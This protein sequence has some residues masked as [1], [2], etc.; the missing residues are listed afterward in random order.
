[1]KAIALSAILIIALF[2]A[3]A[4]AAVLGDKD[5][6]ST[7]VCS[8]GEGDC[9]SDSQCASGL[10]C[11]INSGSNYGMP[12][13]YD[14]CINPAVFDAVGG[15]YNGN[16][17]YCSLKALVGQKC[18]EGQGDCDSDDECQSGLICALDI[19]GRVFGVG[20]EKTDVCTAPANLQSG[21]MD[22]CRARVLLGQKC[23]EAEGDCDSDAECISDAEHNTTCVPDNGAKFGFLGHIDVCATPTTP[24]TKPPVQNGTQ[25]TS[26][27]TRTDYT[28]STTPSIIHN[29][30]FS[31]FYDPGTEK[32]FVGQEISGVAVIDLTDNSR[33]VYRASTTPG[34]D[35][36][37]DAVRSVFYDPG[38][39]KMFVA[40]ELAGVAVID[41]TDG[42]EA[43]YTTTTT[44][45][46]INMWATSVSYDPGTEKMFVGTQDG[47]TVIDLTDNST[48]NYRTTTTPGILHNIVWSVSY[49]PGTEKMFVTTGSGVTVIDLTDNSTTN[50]RTTTT[51][52]IINDWVLSHFYDPT[53]EKLFV[54]TVLGLTVIDLT[55]N[56]R[57]DYTTS[58]TPGIINNLVKSVSYDPGSDRMFVGT[59]L[60][61]T[62]ISFGEAP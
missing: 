45:G 1:M 41:F 30:V 52:G 11:A 18:A 7:A 2:S 14:V 37:G 29:R 28:T 6:C 16:E 40:V 12:Q 24:E 54:G 27:I 10:V 22:F 31:I 44:P 53:T 34:L 5:Y 8:A 51:P 62:V 25:P 59:Q 61:V 26:N 19:G 39:E 4:I 13:N 57:T 20:E 15:A 49:D 38:T 50:Y 58:T 55:D 33:A 32:M 17:A 9:D 42:S 56:S 36:L 60:G 46:V 47:L 21:D 3:I 23:A 35:G 48:T 43:Y